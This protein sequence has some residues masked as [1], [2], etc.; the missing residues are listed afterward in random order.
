MLGP[1]NTPRLMLNAVYEA[2]YLIRSTNLWNIFISL[3]IWERGG[4]HR[5]FK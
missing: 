2:S 4:G 3:I 1:E 5:K